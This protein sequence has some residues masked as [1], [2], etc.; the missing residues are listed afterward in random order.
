M[1]KAGLNNM[2]DY[3]CN[4]SPQ[5]AHKLNEE[6]QTKIEM[7]SDFPYAGRVGKVYSTRELILSDFKYT[8]VYRIHNKNIQI[9]RLLHGAHAV[10]VKQTFV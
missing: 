8:V 7:L 3:V 1:I 5:A 9:L 2:L 6:I 4:E 10:D